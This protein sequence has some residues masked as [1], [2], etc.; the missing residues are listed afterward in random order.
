MLK[1]ISSI[2]LECTLNSKQSKDATTESDYLIHERISNKFNEKNIIN[3]KNTK[4]G[5]T[6]HL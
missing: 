3:L 1:I 4:L 6:L 5:K 2:C